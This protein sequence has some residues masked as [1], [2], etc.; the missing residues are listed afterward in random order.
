MES[1]LKIDEKRIYPIAE[2]MHTRQVTLAQGSSNIVDRFAMYIVDHHNRYT[3]A[4]QV[5]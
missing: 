1:F 5:L 3:A 4:I 2:Q